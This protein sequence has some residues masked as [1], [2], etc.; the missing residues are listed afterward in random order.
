MVPIEAL[1]GI[2]GWGQI[3]DSWSANR[4]VC[5]VC[6]FCPLHSLYLLAELQI[7]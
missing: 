2:I 3:A 1:L 4:S 7:G 6:V 5:V